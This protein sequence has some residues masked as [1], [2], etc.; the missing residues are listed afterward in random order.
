MFTSGLVK[1][2]TKYYKPTKMKNA[3]TRSVGCLNTNTTICFSQKQI[4]I[5][6]TLYAI[7]K[8]DI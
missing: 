4:V 5:F 7:I 1:N 3:A 8:I 2:T 6:T